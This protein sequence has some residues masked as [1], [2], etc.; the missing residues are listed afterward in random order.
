MSGFKKPSGDL[1]AFDRAS[2]MSA[3][4][5]AQTGALQ[6]VPPICSTL[7]LTTR[8]APVLGSAT[9][10]TSGTSRCVPESIPF[11]V[12]HEGRVNRILLPPPLPAHAVSL[13]TPP[14]PVRT[15]RVPPT[16]TTAVSEAS[17]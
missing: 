15:R 8:N 16:P 1:P 2:F 11:P 13:A 3:Q 6:L 7:P 12:C 4:K 14:V 10:L 17:Y 5:P 9:R